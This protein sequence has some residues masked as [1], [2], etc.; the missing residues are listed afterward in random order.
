M[1]MKKR[2]A[3]KTLGCR[4]NQFE[5]DSV[6]T[7]FYKA[8]YEIVGFNEK[9]DVYIINT[10]T[11]TGQGDH[12]SKAAINQALRQGGS[13]V[14][15]AAG[16]MAESSAGELSQV[17]GISYVIGNSYKSDLISLVEGH[18]RGETFST[19]T[20]K[21]NIFGYSVTEKS[22]HTRGM[23]KIQ[24]GCDNFCSYC[25]VP[26]VRGAAVSRPW[27]DVIENVKKLAD[28]G[29]KEIV[30]TGV[31]ISRY[32]FDGIDFSALIARILAIPGEFRLR[33]SSVEPDGLDN[34]FIDLFDNGRL[35]PH[36]HLCL[37]SGSDEVLSRMNRNYKVDSFMK[38]VEAVRK[39]HPLFNFTTDII[40]GF[41]G[42][43]EDDFK[44]TCERVKEAGFSHIHTFKYSVR[45]GT[46]AAG[47]KEQVPDKVK[48]AR[49]TIIR[50]ISDENKIKYRKMF[51]GRAQ[52]MLVEK[53]DRDGNARGYGEHYIPLYFKAGVKDSNYFT[54]VLL[55]EININSK[56][57]SVRAEQIL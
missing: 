25:I 29:Y 13:P 31:N 37:Q 4:L 1:R 16:C 17:D 50:K 33:I 52:D 42:E 56:E 43:T 8:G 6:L 27:T 54:K 14:V 19:D 9:A 26:H 46:V 12:K 23:L 57:L 21:G 55:K 48:A 24:D 20:L 15:I 36:L 41:P 35:C 7:D 28:I 53:T 47:I 10:C 51:I 39:R 30:L 2:V 49:S 32:D 18:F 5:T 40:V 22:F 45:S 44:A 34:R 3:F 38:I 11:V